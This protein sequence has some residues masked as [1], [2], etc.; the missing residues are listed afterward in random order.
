MP[1]NVVGLSEHTMN[2]W[3]IVSE[4][5][6]FFTHTHN[7]ANAYS[8]VQNFASCEKFWYPLDISTFVCNMQKGT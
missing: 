4:F 3:A 2:L 8:G 7:N 5:N 6:A 1:P